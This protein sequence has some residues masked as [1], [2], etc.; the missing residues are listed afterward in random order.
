MTAQCGAD[1]PQKIDSA[2]I[3]PALLALLALVGFFIS[4][5][6]I[7]GCGVITS[8]TCHAQNGFAL[9]RLCGFL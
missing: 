7:A 5:S 1:N 6:I 9:T 2:V 3:G 4:L 8:V